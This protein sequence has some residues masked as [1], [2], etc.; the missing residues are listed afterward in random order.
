MSF[1]FLA[2]WMLI[3][4]RASGLLAVFPVFSMPG[5]PVRLR[6]ALGAL[7]SLFVAAGVPPYPLAGLSLWSLVGVMTL[8]VGAGIF[9]GFLCRMVFYA[10][11]LAGTIMSAEIG[12]NLPATF[13]PNGPSQAPLP[14]AILN[15]LAAVIW[16]V[17]DLHHWLLVAFQR[18]YALLPIGGGRISEPLVHEVLSWVGILF[19]TGLQIAA[20]V[21][22]VSF[23]ISLVFSILGRA[24]SQMNVFTESFAVRLFSGLAIFGFSMPLVAKE[25]AGL[26]RRVPEGL[27]QLSQLL[28]S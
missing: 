13:N 28:G 3:F 10:L 11:E 18:T 15:Y 20:P 27:L 4:L 2:T 6:I 9:L 1:E 25:T 23:I 24:V 19:V 7:L 8:E 14:A 26:F 12:L 16:L 17:L 21:M 22:A 5:I